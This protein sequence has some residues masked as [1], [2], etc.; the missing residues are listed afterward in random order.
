MWALPAVM[1]RIVAER[2]C[3]TALGTELNGQA[4]TL[5]CIASPDAAHAGTRCALLRGW[6]ELV[7]RVGTSWRNR[8]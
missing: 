2:E 5:L 7:E 6:N 8:A 3:L 4:Y 1:L